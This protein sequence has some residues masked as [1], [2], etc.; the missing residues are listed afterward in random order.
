MH[1]PLFLQLPAFLL[2]TSSHHPRIHSTHNPLA[3][4]PVF[5]SF[6]LRSARRGRFVPLFPFLVSLLKFSPR[7]LLYPSFH[8]HLSHS[9]RAFTSFHVLIF[10][11][12]PLCMCVPSLTPSPSLLCS[13]FPFHFNTD[14]SSSFTSLFMSVLFPSR[15]FASLT[16]AY[17]DVPLALD[18][19]LYTP[20]LVHF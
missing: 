18:A 2:C 8:H 5:F 13:T 4:G 6:F 11:Y 17:D 9:I 3:S 12:F 7:S 1:S 20:L 10:N 16:R 14:P 19:F 15:A